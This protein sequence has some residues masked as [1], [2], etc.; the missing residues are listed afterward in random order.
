MQKKSFGYRVYGRILRDL[1]PFLSDRLYLKL[2]F[3]HKVGYSLNLDN[4]RSFNEKLQWLKLNDIHSEYTQMVDKVDAK[5]YVASIIGDEYI[6]PTLGVWNSV[7]EIDWDILPNQFVIKVSSDS[8]GIVVCKNK[9]ELDIELAKRKLKN[10]WGKNYY[11]YNKEYPYRDVKPRIIAEKYM[12]DTVTKELRDYK[13]F[14]FNG[15]PRILKVDY[16]RFIEHRAN[17]YDVNK[18]LLLF[19]EEIC[20][21]DYNK[22]I[23]F[24]DNLDDMVQIARKIAQSIPFVRVDLYNV[25]SQI[26]FGEITFFPASGTGKFTSLEWDYKLGDMIQLPMTK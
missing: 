5:K 2:L 13:F 26:Y 14:C 7:E 1:S 19:G 24:P 6:I 22:K 21:P 12:E 9:A 3:K 8:G 4:P 10:G 20:P 17:Y 11:L 16:N 23:E 15:E 18:N 25:N